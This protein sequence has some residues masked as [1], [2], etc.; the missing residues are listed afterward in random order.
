MEAECRQRFVMSKE[1]TEGEAER[2]LYRSRYSTI[3]TII[4]QEY[5]SHTG[6][7][8]GRE[9][10]TAAGSDPKRPPAFQNQ[11]LAPRRTRLTSF[12]SK[13]PS[14]TFLHFNQ[15]QKA[16]QRSLF[17]EVLPRNQNVFRTGTEKLLVFT[18]RRRRET[19]SLAAKVPQASL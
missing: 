11:L 3:C 6:G 8:G 13:V 12:T 7:G 1:P 4:Q 10:V 2:F 17:S 9:P 19:G 18:I 15:E 5:S 16:E 14:F